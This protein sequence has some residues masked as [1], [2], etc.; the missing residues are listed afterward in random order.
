MKL[1]EYFKDLHSTIYFYGPLKI[2]VTKIYKK[3]KIHISL[4]NDNIDKFILLD[5]IPI[6]KYDNIYEIISNELRKSITKQ[7]IIKYIYESNHDPIT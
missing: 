3:Y 6:K 1:I 7:I 5:A 4:K 2:I